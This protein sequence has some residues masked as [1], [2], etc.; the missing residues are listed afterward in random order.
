M[1]FIINKLR[2]FFLFNYSHFF[3]ILFSLCFFVA[4]ILV[5]FFEFDKTTFF[6]TGAIWLTVTCLMMK[7][8]P[9]CFYVRKETLDIQFKKENKKSSI[10][11]YNL[12]NSNLLRLNCDGSYHNELFP[13]LE[14]GNKKFFRY[15]NEFRPF[16]SVEQFRNVAG[17]Q[18]K[19]NNF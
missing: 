18:D 16:N 15:K 6:I 4:L 19:I 5:R 7:F 13:T 8:L 1:N 14:V 12:L 17:I 2:K 3:I 9:Q 11:E 10:I